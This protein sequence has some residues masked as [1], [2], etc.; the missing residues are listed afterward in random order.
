MVTSLLLDADS[1]APA[2]GR[3]AGVVTAN[4]ERVVG[5]ER[6]R[7]DGH[8]SQRPHDRRRAHHARR[9]GR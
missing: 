6:R 7:H 9:A 2:G 8:V 4:G 1:E 5:P 3:V